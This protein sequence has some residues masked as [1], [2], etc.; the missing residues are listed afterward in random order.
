MD[1]QFTEEQDKFRQQVI[2]FC[3]TEPRGEIGQYGFSPSFGEKIGEKQ[4]PGSSI[5]GEYGGLGLGAVYRVIF[6]EEIAYHRVP[7]IP[8]DYGVTIGLLGN[9]CLKHGTEEQKKEYFPR[10]ARGKIRCGQGYSEPEAGNDLAS[11]QAR[12]ER[13]GDHY[14]VNG[15]KMWVHEARYYQY[16]LLMARTNPDARK[17]Q[18]ISLFILDNA[19]PG[20]SVS[21]QLAMNGQRTPQVFLD[22]VKIPAQNLLGEENHGWNYYLENKP[23]YWNKEQGAETGMM[24]RLFDEVVHYVRETRRR[25]KPLGQ[26]ELIRQKL[27]RIATDIRILRYLIYRMAWMEDRGVDILRISAIT[28]VFHVEAWVRFISV[29]TQI[30]GPGGQ[31]QPGTNYAPLGG[32]MSRLYPAAALQLMQ[33]AGPSYVKSIIAT[34]ILGMPKS[35]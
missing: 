24:R 21:P 3:K 11:I 29:I 7:V 2:D 5:P 13:N 27:A 25:G 12:A 31:L 23:F 30:T 17:E 14:I 20:V 32:M 10:I 26:D 9:I 6:M 34:D 28:R 22:N 19:T 4:W 35:R 16:T 33:R 15:Q 1:L 18:G 8:Y